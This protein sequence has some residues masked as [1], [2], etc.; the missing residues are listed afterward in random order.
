LFDQIGAFFLQNRVPLFFVYGLSFLSLGAIIIYS[1]KRYGGPETS[2]KYYA[3]LDAFLF[4]ALFG[5]VHGINEW[6]DMYAIFLGS[7]ASTDVLVALTIVGTILLITSFG[8]LLQFAVEIF[9]VEQPERRWMRGFPLGA[10]MMLLFLVFYEGIIESGLAAG[11]FNTEVF[12]EALGFF[13][14]FLSGLTLYWL[15]SNFEKQGVSSAAVGGTKALA[16]SFLVYSFFTSFLRDPILGIPSEV[17]R[18]LLALLAAIAAWRIISLFSFRIPEAPKA[19]FGEKAITLANVRGLAKRAVLLTG[20]PALMLANKALGK[21]PWQF[22]KDY[23]L[24]GNPKEA[25]AVR[26]FAMV[27]RQYKE[28]LGASVTVGL[29][30]Y[31]LNSND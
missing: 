5:V 10:T 15:S 25:D 30:Q 11:A 18:T 2:Y 24:S 23:S 14:A 4:L 9:T 13:G 19:L 1:Q 26:M 28:V 7:A 20:A 6:V 21:T 12:F 8:F 3:F 16:A 27:T 22:D 17:F 29:V 31:V